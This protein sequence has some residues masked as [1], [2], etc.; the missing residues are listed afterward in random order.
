[1]TTTP[2]GRSGLYVSSPRAIPLAVRY[3]LDGTEG[4]APRAWLDGWCA[5]YR[6]TMRPAPRALDARQPLLTL[7]D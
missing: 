6:V 3:Q 7:D 1:M 4:R 2:R 5:S